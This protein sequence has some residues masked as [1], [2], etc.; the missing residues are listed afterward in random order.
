MKKKVEAMSEQGNP[1]FG[2]LEEMKKQAATIEKVS[3]LIGKVKSSDPLLIDAGEIQ[4]SRRDVLI[5]DHLL[6]GHK[7]TVLIDS[8][9]HEIQTSDG[10][11]ASDQV[12]IL[13]S[14]DKQTFV[15]TSRLL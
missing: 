13:V 11:K 7:R 2:L 1:F 4:L 10:L 15:V 14:A 3:F 5:S 8:I 6:A 9:E 12:L